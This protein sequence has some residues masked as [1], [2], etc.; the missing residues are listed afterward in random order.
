[1]ARDT[2]FSVESKNVEYKITLPDKSEKYMKTIVAFAN[3]Q[4]GKLIV[5]IDDKT[6]EI[7]GVENEIL[8]QVMDGIANFNAAK[9]YGLLEP[10]FQEFDNMFRVELFRNSLP[11][12]SENKHIGETS[13]KHRRNME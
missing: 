8:F 12:T 3:T 4:G 10:K 5:G 7:V 2:L 1:M 13:E 11:M 9:E 6:H